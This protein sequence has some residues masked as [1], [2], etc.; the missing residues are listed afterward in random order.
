MEFP[1]E[2]IILKPYTIERCHKFFKDYI[3]DPAMTYDS[4]VYDKEKVDRY[5][6]IKY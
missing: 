1:G 2:K 3:S 6:K 4:F 5:Y